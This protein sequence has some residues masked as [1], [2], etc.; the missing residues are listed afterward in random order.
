MEVDES[1]LSEISKFHY[2]LELVKD[3]PREDIVGLPHSIEGDKEAKCILQETR[4]KDSKVH[5]AL[6]KDLESLHTITRIQKL[7]T[8]LTSIT[9]CLEL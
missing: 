9:N 5:S 7:E 1:S 3:K 8:I 2:L 4:G 6:I